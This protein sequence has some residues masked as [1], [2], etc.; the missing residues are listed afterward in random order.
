MNL[1]IA[2][3]FISWDEIKHSKKFMLSSP[4]L[5]VS[6]QELITEHKSC[7]Q[8][9]LLDHETVLLRLHYT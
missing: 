3:M 4:A 7:Q 6:V 9:H 2:R 8:F 1:L 5:Y